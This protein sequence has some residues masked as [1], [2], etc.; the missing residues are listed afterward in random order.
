MRIKEFFT[1]NLPIKILAVIGAIFLWTYVINEGYR[2]D[3]LDTE[4][5]IESF[6]ISEDLALVE[7]LGNVTLKVRVPT[8]TSTK[9]LLKD[10]K[11]FIDL[12]GLRPGSYEKEIKVSFEDPSISLLEL[13]PQKIN[14][15][16]ENL[17]SIEKE[18][19]V[20]V[21]GEVDQNYQTDDAVLSIDKSEIKGASS[22]LEKIEK[23]VAPINVTDEMS[24]I[25]KI[26]ELE[27]RDSNNEKVKGITIH[28]KSVEITIPLHTKEELK[29]V[30]VKANITGN[31]AT[32]YFISRTSI[33]PA[34]ISIKGET[35]AV[36][37]VSYLN[38]EPINVT[39][40]NKNTEINTSLEL[41]DGIELS[42]MQLVTVSIELEGQTTARTIDSI[43]D[44]TNLDSSL[45]L[46][47]YDPD[48][49]KVLVEG[50][51]PIINNLTSGGV[52]TSIDLTGKGAGSFNLPI[53]PAMIRLPDG[54]TLKSIETKN[55]KITI[56]K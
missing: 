38:T 33:N 5:P 9:S 46:N 51:A 1:K 12:K 37:S 7:D 32:G 26:V 3:F 45:E 27:A 36:S 11:A 43:I 6:N 23:L 50:N 35:E 4:I 24:E 10:T 30:G 31:P 17:E 39:G 15:T 21:L 18:I 29:T 13:E 2:V 54:V 56:K 19:E 52:I 44:F 22:S 41:P 55:I 42:D 8:S 25:K 40:F 16:L 28:P 14:I 53:D 20:E 48:T 49:I 34:T 47:S